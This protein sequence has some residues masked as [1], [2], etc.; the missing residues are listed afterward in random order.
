L[1]N[2]EVLGIIVPIDSNEVMH[3]I[4]HGK[5]VHASLAD[6]ERAALEKGDRIF[7]YDSGRTHC[8]MGEAVIADI[9]FDEA[10]SVLDGLGPELYIGQ[11]DFEKYVSSLP[12]G[13]KSVLRLVHFRDAVLYANPMK[14]HLAIGENGS[15]VT[16][17][18]SAK[19]AKD[20]M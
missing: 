14:C 16:A 6:G 3:D 11:D 7:F 8:I 9:A 17:E 19:I 2:R 18:V 13:D 4:F 10:K 1:G 12:G 15:Y 5:S 20:N